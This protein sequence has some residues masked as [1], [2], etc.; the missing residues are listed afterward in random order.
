MPSDIDSPRKSVSAKKPEKLD[1]KKLTRKPAGDFEKTRPDI[2][3]SEDQGYSFNFESKM[4]SAKESSS[5]EE[6]ALI[7]YDYLQEC[8]KIQKYDILY[9]E[10]IIICKLERKREGFPGG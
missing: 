9:P 1:L 10:Y 8:Y 2:G 6:D 5:V 7:E 4:E 3:E